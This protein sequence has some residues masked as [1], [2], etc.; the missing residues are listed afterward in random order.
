VKRVDQVFGISLIL[1]FMYWI[2]LVTNLGSVSFLSSLFEWTT[3]AAIVLGYPGTFLVSLLGSAMVIVEVPFAGVPFVLGGLRE[4]LTGPFIFDP[5]LLGLLSG[6]GATIG[7]MTSYALGYLGRRVVNE[8]NT[9][10]FSRFVQNYPRATPVAVFILAATPLPLDPAVVALGVARYSWWKLFT[11][12][13]IGEIVFLTMVSWGGRLS[14]DWL[15]GIFGIGGPVT[16]MSATVEVLSIIL[17]IV[18]VYLAVR[19]DWTTIAEKLREPEVN[20][21]E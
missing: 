15:I 16:L 9:S 18:T 8:A 20:A 6:I 3:D 14:L 19:L 11:P 1:V 13:L 2:I 5:W 17:L 7:D 10:G 4:G 12:C 21:T